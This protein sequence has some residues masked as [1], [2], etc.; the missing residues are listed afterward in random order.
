MSWVDELDLVRHVGLLLLKDGVASGL[1]GHILSE[2]DVMVLL[3]FFVIVEVE[4]LL[5]GAVED[6][7]VVIDVLRYLREDLLALVD[8]VQLVILLLH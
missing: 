2:V 5:E 4:D 8:P 1:G 3:P 7:C 6:L